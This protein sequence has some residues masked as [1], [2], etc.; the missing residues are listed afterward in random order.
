VSRDTS[1]VSLSLIEIIRSANIAMQRFYSAMQPG[2]NRKL[3]KCGREN[4]VEGLPPVYRI[5]T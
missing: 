4:S 2:E 3:N 1:V 5:F